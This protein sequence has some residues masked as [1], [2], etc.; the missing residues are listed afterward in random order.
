MRAQGKGWA[1][2]ARAVQ[3]DRMVTARAAMRIA[4]GW[5]Q[6]EAADEWN[7]RWPDDWKEAKTFSYWE[8][9][10]DGGGGRKPSLA[11]LARLADMYEC[12]LDDL[13]TD[14]DYA[15]LETISDASVRGAATMDDVER[16]VFILGGASLVAAPS[17][18][19]GVLLAA[20]D[21]SHTSVSVGQ[22]EIDEILAATS[23]LN[24]ADHEH[25]GGYAR[26][27][28]VVQLRHAAGLL[29]AR[30]P[31]AL[32]PDLFSAVAHLAD[33]CAFMTFDAAADQRA[34]RT[35]RVM[36]NGALECTEEIGDWHLQVAVLVNLSRQ[37]LWLAKPDEAL[38]LTERAL[39]LS[40]HISPRERAL[41]WSTRASVHAQRGDVPATV[42]AIKASDGHFGKAETSDDEPSWM[43]YYDG[44]EHS[45]STGHA[46]Y[47]L[48]M[49]TGC[50]E[51]DEAV[52]RQTAAVDGFPAGEARSKALSGAR[53]AILQMRHGDPGEAATTGQ[54]TLDVAG[55]IHS[56]R[57]HRY[58][59]LLAKAATP[60]SRRDRVGEL[61]A[62][63]PVP[64]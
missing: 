64:A 28:A 60:H 13:L 31:T 55:T 12:G 45:S 43:Y 7:R 32:R 51:Y 46:L 6:N 30:C 39:S 41:V 18:A 34:D 9:W 59:A 48:V 20:L 47:D 16:R 22:S 29:Q 38:A 40:H 11:Q 19:A 3:H 33:N 2:I 52:K 1:E 26:S 62:R 50:G 54:A 44:A 36:W 58:L 37:A 8:S 49:S 14:V 23:L 25:G 21:G 10:P 57:T 27:L 24:R 61:L 63:L 4:H 35:A 15:T 53:L 17:M 56:R 42:A 5:T